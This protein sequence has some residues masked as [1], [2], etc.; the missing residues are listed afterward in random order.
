L[1][2]TSDTSVVRN[3]DETSL[4]ASIAGNSIG[5]RLAYDYVEENWDSLYEK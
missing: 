4:I 2:K 3:Q 1:Y 5:S